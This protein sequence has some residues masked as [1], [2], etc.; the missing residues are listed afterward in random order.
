MFLKKWLRKRRIEKL[1]ALFEKRGAIRKALIDYYKDLQINGG[2][3]DLIPS[4]KADELLLKV[5]RT[6]KDIEFYYKK[7]Q[8][9][10]VSERSK[11][12]VKV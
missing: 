1:T 5:L 6:P 4:L 11:T 10:K 2:E 8:Q 7:L 9:F 3:V 12:N